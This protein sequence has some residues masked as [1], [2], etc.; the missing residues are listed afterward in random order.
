MHPNVTEQNLVIT[1]LPVKEDS[2]DPAE[3]ESQLSGQGSTME[4]PDQSLYLHPRTRR[5]TQWTCATLKAACYR[6]EHGNHCFP[7]ANVSV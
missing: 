3:G 7:N 1:V 4:V 6:L 2:R 5:R